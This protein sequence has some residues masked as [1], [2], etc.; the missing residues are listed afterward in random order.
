MTGFPNQVREM[1]LRRADGRCERCGMHCDVLQLHHRRPRGMGGSTDPAT[2]T[3]SNAVGLCPGCHAI[4]ESK[5]L[6]AEYMGFLVGQ[7]H[8]PAAVPVFRWGQWVVLDA[9]GGYEVRA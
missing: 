6:D 3:A 4:C 2:N 9:A 5:R 8:D 7:G 1:V